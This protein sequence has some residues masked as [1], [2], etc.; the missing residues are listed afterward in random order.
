M[1]SIT[2]RINDDI[3][4]SKVTFT[5]MPVGHLSIMT[6]DQKMYKYKPKDDI[7]GIELAHMLHLFVA[8]V[9]ASRNMAIYDYWAFVEEHNL[10][11]HFEA[12]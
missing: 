1:S 8:A 2:D 6:P 9:T 10:Q 11:R 5:P 4:T 3:K 7:T 12:A